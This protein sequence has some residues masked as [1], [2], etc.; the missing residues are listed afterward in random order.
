MYGFLLILQYTHFAWPSL[1]YNLIILTYICGA[2]TLVGSVLHLYLSPASLH[3]SL[4]DCKHSCTVQLY[5]YIR[6]CQ[7]G[8]QNQFTDV[9]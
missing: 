3:G 2:H 8:L 5:S 9:K 6:N 4:L 7:P 1:L